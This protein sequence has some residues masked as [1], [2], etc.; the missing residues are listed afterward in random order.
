MI[1]RC[2]AIYVPMKII[3]SENNNLDIFGNLQMSHDNFVS[4]VSSLKLV[5]SKYYEEYGT[6]HFI[7]EIY[8]I[9]KQI[10]FKH[11]C[12]SF[13]LKYVTKLYLLMKLYYTLKKINL[14]FKTANKNKLIIWRHE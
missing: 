1:H 4:F 5:F 3:K 6:R 10:N 13:P 14:N 2:F 11:P 8:I 12:T 7:K 9:C